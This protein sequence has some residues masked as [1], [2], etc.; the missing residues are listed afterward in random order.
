MTTKTTQT[1]TTDE[2]E[3]PFKKGDWVRDNYG[4]RKQVLAVQENMVWTWSPAATGTAG[5]LY[6]HTKL[7]A[8]R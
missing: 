5:N 8:A 1:T 3:N 4:E 7:H 6:H 2:T